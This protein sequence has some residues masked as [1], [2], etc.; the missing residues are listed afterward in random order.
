VAKQPKANSTGEE[1][2]DEP[3]ALTS[4]NDR[5]IDLPDESIIEVEVPPHLATPGG[6]EGGGVDSQPSPESQSGGERRAGDEGENETLIALRKKVADDNAAAQERIRIAEQNTIN[7]RNA[8]LQAEQNH[9]QE[10]QRSQ[11]QSSQRELALL[12]QN[13]EST[14]GQL[15][16]LQEEL[17]RQN[18][19]G[20]F[21]EAAKTQG[22]IARTAAA[23]DRMENEKASFE[24]NASQR[25]G[26]S[27]EGAVTPPQ[28]GGQRQQTVGAQLEQWLSTLDPP[29]AKW[30][31]D[32]PECAPPNLGGTKSGYA[33]MMAGH[34]AAEE[35]GVETNSPDYFRMIEERTGHRQATEQPSSGKRPVQ[36]AGQR[37]VIPS[38]PPS[39]EAP[40][41]AHT[42]G[43]TRQVRLS[44][45]QQEHALLSYPH[46]APQAALAEY[47]RNLVELEA[48]GKMGRTNM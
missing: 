24:T 18:E 34:W 44:K 39:R 20:E 19:A 3:L 7:E 11:E 4:I 16:S 48:E 40:G 28:P 46:L 14:S 26:P 36:P 33:K 25:R 21:K 45:Q 1:G 6:E 17:A 8:R 41:G 22:R 10:Q 37:R 42:P 23:L 9:Q 43:R 2:G 47:A 32:H 12:T 13:I 5:L 27:H 31:R 38:A 29:A 15:E 35:A 30:I